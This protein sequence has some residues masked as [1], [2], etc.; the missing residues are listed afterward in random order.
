MVPIIY[1]KSFDWHP[2]G[3]NFQNGRLSQKFNVY[4][5]SSLERKIICRYRRYEIL[6]KP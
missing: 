1:Y 4:N 3:N 2:L 5:W 6:T